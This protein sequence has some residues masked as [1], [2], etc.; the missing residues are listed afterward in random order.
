MGKTKTNR[1]VTVRSLIEPFVDVLFL[2]PHPCSRTNP[3]NH[4]QETWRPWVVQNSRSNGFSSWQKVPQSDCWIF[5]GG[6]GEK[7]INNRYYYTTSSTHSMTNDNANAARTG[8]VPRISHH[9]FPSKRKVIPH[10]LQ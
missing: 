5:T 4:L 3:T 8:F 10:S 6:E 2:P 1:T 9:Q 7:E